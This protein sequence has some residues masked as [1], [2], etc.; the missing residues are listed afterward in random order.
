MVATVQ[1][2]KNLLVDGDMEQAGVVGW[3]NSNFPAVTK[4]GNAWQGKRCLRV[5]YTT[6]PNPTIYQSLLTIG[7]PY[8]VRGRGRSDG[9]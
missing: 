5:A 3:S 2:F 9:V 1:R 8:R 7:R 4:Q 6:T